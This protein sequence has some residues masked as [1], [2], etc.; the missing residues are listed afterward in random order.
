M[1]GDLGRIKGVMRLEKDTIRKDLRPPTAAYP[2]SFDQASAEERKSNYTSVVNKY[3]DLATD[4]YEFGWGSSFHFAPRHKWESLQSSIERHELWL[5]NRLGL[6]PGMKVMDIG[7]GVGGP[8]RNIARFSKAQ[9]LGL[10]NNEY[11]VSRA[12]KIAA[13]CKMGNLAAFIK[14]DFMNIPA[15]PETFDAA[16]AIE[17]TCH[18]PDRVGVYSQIFKILKPGGQ[19]G[20][21][22]WVMTDKYN[23]NNPAHV[24]GKKGIE[25]GNGLPDLEHIGVI[26]DALKESGFEIIEQFD[27]APLSDIPWYM[28]LVG[29]LTPTGIMHTKI[30]R[31]ISLK[32]LQLLEYIKIAPAGSGG[33]LE[34]LQKGSDA[35]CYS[36]QEETFTPMYWV[37]ARKPTK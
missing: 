2:P 28:P 13:D 3:Y 37:L 32:G 26:L 21:Y 35:L 15:E 22:E 23:P 12:R 11:Q 19:L 8:L 25:R 20:L 27:I 7:C 34:M 9:V 29:R 5:A 18:A 36:G 30:G 16:Y 6:R 10:N 33:T 14:G 17:A 1:D 4:F 31:W 24:A